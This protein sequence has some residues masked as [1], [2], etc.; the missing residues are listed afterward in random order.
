ML[1]NYVNLGLHINLGL[2]AKRRFHNDFG[3]PFYVVSMSTS[4]CQPWPS[5]RSCSYL[6]HCHISMS[7]LALMSI[8]QLSLPWSHLYVS[9]GPHVDLAVISSMVTSLC[10]PWPSCRSCSYLFHGHISMS[11]LA[12]MSILQLSLPWS[13]LFVS[14]GP[15]VDLAVIS[16]MVTSLCQPWPSCRS[17][18]YLFHGHISMSALALMSILQLS[19]PWAHLHVS[20]GP[21]VDLAVISSMVTSLC[22]PW[23]SCRSCSY[24]FHGH[25]SMSALALMS[26]LQLSLPWSH[27]FVSLGPHVDLAVISSMVTSLCQ[28]WPSCRSCSYLFHGHISM[29]ALALMSIL[30]LSLPWTHLHVSLGPHVDLA[31]ISSMVTSLCQPWPSCRSCSYLFHVHLSMSALALMSIL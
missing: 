23:P 6:F 29:S 2:H 11:A 3:F 8:L 9:L 28:P 30:Q 12:L 4:P 26:I 7:A 14:L 1:K 27:L 16:S 10:Q 18:S 13:H 25:I 5:C 20:L 17:C 21:H 15:H 24:L 22:Q 31:V 19:L